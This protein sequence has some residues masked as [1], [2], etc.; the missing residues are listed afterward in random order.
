[1]LDQPDLFAGGAGADGGDPVL[2]RGEGC[3]VFGQAVVDAPFGAAFREAASSG[4]VVEVIE[5]VSFIRYMPPPA[6]HGAVVAEW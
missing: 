6:Y 5:P 1:M 4:L 2:H 3:G